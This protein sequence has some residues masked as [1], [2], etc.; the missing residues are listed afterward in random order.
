MQLPPEVVEM[1]NSFD[2]TQEINEDDA[3]D[4]INEDGTGDEMAIFSLSSLDTLNNLCLE[5]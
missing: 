2:S 5:I 1:I 4:E 3:G